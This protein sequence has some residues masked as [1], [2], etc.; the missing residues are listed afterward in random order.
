MKI[1]V[2]SILVTGLALL[3]LA[4]GSPAFAAKAKGE[5][6][7]LNSASQSELEALPGVGAATAKK[8]L[9]NR[10]YSSVADLSRTRPSQRFA[11]S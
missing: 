1:R 3:F 11:T 2:R 9:A 7:D 6:V 8:I 4:A 5:K 10:P